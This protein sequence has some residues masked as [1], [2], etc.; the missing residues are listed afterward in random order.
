[1]RQFWLGMIAVAAVWGCGGGKEATAPNKPDAPVVSVVAAIGGVEN[2]R[3]LVTGTTAFQREPILSFRVP[4]VIQGISVDEGDRVRAGQR[5][6]WLKP[7]EVAAGAAEAKAALDTAERNLARQQTL[8]EK[9]F[10]SQ[11]RIDDAKL[12]VERAKAGAEA[13]GFSRDTAIIIAPADGVILRRLAEPSQ[14]A[15]AGAPILLLGEARSGFIVRASAASQQAALLKIGAPAKV[16]V[17]GAGEINGKI[18]RLAAKGDAATGAF[19]IEIAIPNGPAL[20]SGMVAEA[21]IESPGANAAAGAVRVPTLALLDA[22]ADQGVV[23]VVDETGVARRRP[24][25]TAGVDGESAIVLSGLK[26]GERVVAAGAAYVRDGE[27]V[28]IAAETK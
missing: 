3:I 23:Y 27:P 2:G 14:V 24:V 19:D 8:F 5:L 13:A 4:G 22:R 26:P 1:M 7:T 15:G 16:T 12:A 17:R 11:A 25:T 28:A 18:S 20:R 6:A 10:V 9:G 21:L